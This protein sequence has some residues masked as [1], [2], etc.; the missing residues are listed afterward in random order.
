MKTSE[1][2]EQLMDSMDKNGDLEVSVHVF[3]GVMGSFER[4]TGLEVTQLKNE[5]NK[6]EIK[7]EAVL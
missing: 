2:I 7:H 3:D 6:L 5:D 4:I 1:L